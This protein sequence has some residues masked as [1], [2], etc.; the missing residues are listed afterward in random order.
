MGGAVGCPLVVIMT[1]APASY[2]PAG[3]RVRVVNSRLICSVPFSNKRNRRNSNAFFAHNIEIGE[4]LEA[5]RD[6]LAHAEIAS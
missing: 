6:Q 1:A 3:D 5:C 4:V 2:R